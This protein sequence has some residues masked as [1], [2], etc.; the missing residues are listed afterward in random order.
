MIRRNNFGSFKLYRPIHR[1]LLF[2]ILFILIVPIPTAE[3]SIT[4]VESNL[5]FQILYYKK[6][7][8]L[9]MNNNY[10]AATGIDLIDKYLLLK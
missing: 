5:D 3:S 7:V 6:K 9:N 8:I 10:K 2:V 1:L 4:S